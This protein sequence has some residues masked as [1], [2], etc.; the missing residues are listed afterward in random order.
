MPSD[1]QVSNIKDL[2]GSNTGLSIASDGQVTIAQNNPTLT[3]G[4]NATF[5]TKVTDRTD[6]YQLF[7]S[8]SDP[9]RYG[10]YLATSQRANNG[11]AETTIVVPTGYSSVANAYLWLIAEFTGNSNVQIQWTCGSNDQ[12]QGTH[13]QAFTSLS[14]GSASVTNDY[15]KRLDILNI[16]STHW[17]DTIVEGDAMGMRFK[18]VTGDNVRFLGVSI[19]WRF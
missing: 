10:N 3:L 18:H 2:T 1:L 4:S 15:L 13:T 12:A 5:P 14:S 11:T 17:E 8:S 9:V 19:T 7:V 6:F 16:G